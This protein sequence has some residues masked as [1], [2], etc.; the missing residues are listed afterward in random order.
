MTLTY[1]P[2][3]IL[4]DIIKHTLPEGFE[5]V[6]VTCKKLHTLCTPFIKRHNT[7]RSHFYNFSYYERFDKS[8]NVHT[9]FDLISCIATDPTVARYIRH[10]DFEADSQ[11]LSWRCF[12]LA[13]PDACRADIVKL[14]AN[15][16]YLKQAGLPWREYY[17]KIEEDVEARRVSLHAAAFLLTLLPNVETLQLPRF[18]KSLD[19]T[20]RLID[21]LAHKA[22]QPQ[23]HFDMP[24]LVQVTKIGPFVKAYSADHFDL[25]W[26]SPFLA[27]PHVQSFRSCSCVKWATGNI[28]TP[29]NASPRIFGESLVKVELHSCCIDEEGIAR[30]LENTTRLKTFSYSHLTKTNDEQQDW[31][32]GKF[33]TAIE[34]KVGIHLEQL[35]IAICML[36]GSITPD[37]VSMRGFQRLQRLRFPVALA[38]GHIAATTS[39]V[40]M[41]G[42]CLSNNSLVPNGE[43]FG[44]LIEDLVPVSVSQL[45][46]LSRGTES[47]RKAL[48]AMFR[49][50][51][52]KRISHLPFLKEVE[53]DVRGDKH[54][55]NKHQCA[56][57]R[58]KTQKVGVI[59]R[60]PP[61]DESNMAWK[62]E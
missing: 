51:I 30:F 25:D 24:S 59:L 36:R 48:D 49:D 6:A 1:L 26:A 5:N 34:Q 41:Q 10:A 38:L 4:D 28:I 43:H 9:A 27:L 3:E 15:S 60:A 16:P 29:P 32:I 19:A 20:D 55:A 57:L 40:P 42:R 37:K 45:S 8:F 56:R 7:L 21:A 50:L 11:R 61:W 18:W 31:N 13:H 33:V 47:H 44:S 14:F 23:L 46:L 35:S 53:I 52:T 22:R 58:M 39:Q 2:T 62:E 54:K 17:A 12:D